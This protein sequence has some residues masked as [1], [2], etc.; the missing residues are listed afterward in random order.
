MSAWCFL[1][2]PVGPPGNDGIPGQPGL[3][4]P[5]GPPGPPG[6][7]GVSISTSEHPG[8]QESS[9]ATVYK[10]DIFLKNDSQVRFN[11]SLSESEYIL[12]MILHF[13]HTWGERWAGKAR[14]QQ[15]NLLSVL[16]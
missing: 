5:P 6:L 7:G 9:F 13:I 16:I 4:G 2:G 1:Q 12:P 14:K 8:S 10:S 15:I 11:L 3:P